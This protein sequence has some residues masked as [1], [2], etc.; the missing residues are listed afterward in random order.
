[1][2]WWELAR[3]QI[4]EARR[5]SGWSQQQLADELTAHGFPLSGRAIGKIETGHIRI[6]LVLLEK[7]AAITN[8]P[9]EFFM[10][11]QEPKDVARRQVDALLDQ[12]SIDDLVELRAL[13]QAK[14]EHRR[15]A[16][17]NQPLPKARS[18]RRAS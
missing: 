18:R 14:L 6:D 13:A 4:R 16:P 11:D 3:A 12:L 8:Q 15:P 17:A 10:P 5:R 2:T 7:I 9:I 1:M